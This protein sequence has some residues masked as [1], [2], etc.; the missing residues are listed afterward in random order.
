MKRIEC[1]EKVGL[2]CQKSIKSNAL[3]S[4]YWYT[5]LNY[6]ILIYYFSKMLK[7]KIKHIKHINN[8]T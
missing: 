8:K 2:K 5:W 3:T 6:V 7:Q 1:I 4:S